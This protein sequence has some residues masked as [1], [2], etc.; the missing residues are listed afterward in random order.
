MPGE[1][2]MQDQ[3]HASIWKSWMVLVVMFAFV[4]IA[5][6][7]GPRQGRGARGQVRNQGGA[8]LKKARPEAGDPLAK[9]IAAPARP[10]PGTFHYILRLRSFD[11]TPLAATFYPSKL[12][13]SAPVLM[14]IHEMGR[15]RK[16]FEDAVL[17]LKSQGLAEHLQG[18]GYGV[19]SMDLR[20]RIPARARGW[21]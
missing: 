16:D 6:A 4:S 10:A 13:S 9:I 2:E 19:F 7:Q 18:L 5:L 11:G 20:G 21:L 14:L 15:S 17:D 8:P 1:S 3:H 12:G